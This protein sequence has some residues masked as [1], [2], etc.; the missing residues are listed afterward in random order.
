MAS[1]LL[2]L[3]PEGLGWSLLPERA[4]GGEFLK[5]GDGFL[6]LEGL[7]KN[8]TGGMMCRCV[9]AYTLLPLCPG[10]AAGTRL[11]VPELL[12]SDAL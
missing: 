12:R 6:F 1:L 7:L 8:F 5:A 11:C 9:I 3:E 10:S 4:G 2:L